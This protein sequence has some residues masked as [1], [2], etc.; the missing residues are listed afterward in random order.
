MLAAGW[1]LTIF[2]M[3]WWQIPGL[4][5]VVALIIFYIQWKKKQV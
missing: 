1:F 2:P 5:V 4:I 3:W